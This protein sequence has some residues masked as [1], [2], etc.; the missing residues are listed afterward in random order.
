MR[1][2]SKKSNSAL[3]TALVLAG[4]GAASIF[5]YEKF[6]QNKDKKIRQCFERYEGNFDDEFLNDCTCDCENDANESYATITM[7]KDNTCSCEDGCTECDDS[8][9]DENT[10]IVSESSNDVNENSDEELEDSNK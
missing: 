3:K 1:R 6:V 8:V 9:T 10:D 7:E 2:N 5:V 4:V